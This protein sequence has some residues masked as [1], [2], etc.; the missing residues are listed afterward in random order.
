[1][2]D[3]TFKLDANKTM[4]DPEL[5][6]GNLPLN[7]VTSMLSSQ[8]MSKSPQS[9]SSTEQPASQTQQSTP[10][11]PTT[12][13]PDSSLPPNLDKELEK[14]LSETPVNTDPSAAPKKMP[15]KIIAATAAILI[16]GGGAAAYLFLG[17][18]TDSPPENTSATQP[19]TI[20]NPFASEDESETSIDPLESDTPDGPP[21]ISFPSVAPSEIP[22]DAETSPEMDD[23]K[24]TVDEL[25]ET[26]DASADVMDVPAIED[27]PPVS[28]PII[29]DTTDSPKKVSR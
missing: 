1:M 18:G 26:S 23:L 25:K 20:S 10:T 22:A 3:N 21:S 16:I 17:Q 4:P 24:A 14:Q 15:V 19:P 2:E 27:V 28:D 29:L 11:D 8:D 5:N 7:A 13:S 9:T 6:T 12:P